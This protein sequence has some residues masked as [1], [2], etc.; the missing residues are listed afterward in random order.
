[1]SSCRRRQMRDEQ[2]LK[3]L[4]ILCKRMGVGGYHPFDNISGDL[5]GR[6]IS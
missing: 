3:G 5:R 1:M 2:R 4:T 6:V